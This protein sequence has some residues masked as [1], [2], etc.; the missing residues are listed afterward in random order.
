MVQKGKKIIYILQLF[1]EI[2]G[3]AI[4]LSIKV[5]WITKKKK[6]QKKP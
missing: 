4:F 5:Y 1:Y 2:L 6:E 3:I